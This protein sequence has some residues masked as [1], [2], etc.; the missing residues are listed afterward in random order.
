[1]KN[2]LI[3]HCFSLSCMHNFHKYLAITSL[4]EAWGF[5]VT[6]VGYSRIDP[7]Q[8]YPPNQEHPLTHS[9]TWNKGRI[10]NDYYIIFISKGQGI[11]ESALSQPT[12]ITAGTC[13]FLFPG[14]WH[15]YKPDRG[16]GWEEYW[17]GFRGGYPDQLMNKGFFSSNF[18]IVSP[19]LSDALLGLVQKVVE[20]VRS[21]TPGYHQVISGITLQI[22]GLVH[23]LSTH[24]ELTNDVDEQAVEKAKFFLR[25]NLEAS[26]DMKQMIREFPM[27]YS[28]F[29]K[30]FKHATGESPNQYHLNMRLDKARELLN[31]TNLNVTE[32]A[33]NLGFES[34]FYFSKLFKKKNGVS[35]KS[36]RAIN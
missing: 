15:R 20:N 27:S 11:F 30:M 35:P 12:V 33:Y 25:E 28:K 22:L 1:M 23:A 4:E 14:V 2:V 18:P 21:G 7:N 31:T 8:V 5:Y 3:F 6:T 26:L 36:Y 16:T 19:G 29:R 17:I 9:F 13:F 24:K 10:L 34:V 32:V